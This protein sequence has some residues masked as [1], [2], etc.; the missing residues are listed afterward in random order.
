MVPERIVIVADLLKNA[1]GKIDR[2]RLAAQLAS[3]D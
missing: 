2:R 3:G 1:N